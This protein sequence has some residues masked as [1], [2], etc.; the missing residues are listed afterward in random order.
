MVKYTPKETVM[1]KPFQA[2]TWSP[3]MRAWCAQVTD[4]PDERSTIVFKRGTSSG[5]NGRTPAGGQLPPRSTV[6][7]RLLWKKAQKKEAKNRTSDRI[8]SSIP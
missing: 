7:A 1:I 5:L 3:D 2:L 4:A 6:G 8:N